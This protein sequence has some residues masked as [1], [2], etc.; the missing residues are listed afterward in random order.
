MITRG[1]FSEEKSKEEQAL[2][3]T[4]EGRGGINNK[5]KW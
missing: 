4:A 2:T 3:M 1:A 5:Q